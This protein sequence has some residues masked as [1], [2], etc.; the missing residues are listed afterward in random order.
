MKHIFTFKRMLAVFLAALMTCLSVSVPVSADSLTEKTFTVFSGQQVIEGWY[1]SF[2]MKHENPTLMDGFLSAVQNP[3]AAIE[4]TYTGSADISLLL[5]S[6]PQ[7]GGNS[8]PW[9]SYGDCSIKTSGNRNVAV[10]SASGLIN[11]YTSKKHDDDGQNLRLDNLMNFAIGGEGNTVYSVIVRWTTDGVPSLNINLNSA[12]QTIEGFGASYTWYGDWITSSNKKNQVFDWIFNDCEFNI[13][14]F[15][16]LNRVR[17]YGG[18]FEDTNYRARAYKAYYD[19]AVSRGIKP[20]VLVTSWGEYRDEDWVEFVDRGMHQT[21][22][23]NVPWTYYTL[24]KDSSGNYRYNDLADFCVKSVQLFFDAGIPVDYFSISNEVELQDD[25]LDEQGNPRDYSGFFFDTEETQYACSYAKAY[26]AVY[27]AFKKAFGDKAP[28]LLA[29]ETMAATPNLIKS[30][31]DPILRER[32]ETVTTIAHHLYGSAN[33]ASEFSQISNMYSSRYSIWQTEWYTNNLYD[34]A[35]EIIRELTYENLNAY[36]Y[37]D[38]VWVPDDGNCL[39]ELAGDTPWNPNA[40]AARR[41]PHYIMMHFSKYI[42]KGYIRV[43]ANSSGTGCEYVAFKSPEND[44]LVIVALNK[45]GASDTVRLNTGATVTGSEI[46]RST[47]NTTDHT[48]EQTQNSYMQKVSQTVAEGG[49]VTLPA[50]TL[51]T[52]VLDISSVVKGDADGSGNVELAD[53]VAILRSLAHLETPKF[54]PVAADLNN[55]GAVE[56]ADAVAVLR[57]LAHLG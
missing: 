36:L 34:L 37:W 26:I 33:T 40:Y 35:S 56:L 4:I 6:Y 31:V 50:N 7:G 38:G 32:P 22:Q 54:Y 47:L 53:A 10:F 28:K 13:L 52:I 11:T 48:K 29:P 1:P 45:T 19:A 44:K 17:G 5:M 2:I 30:Y 15:R 9:V 24:K 18:S 12:H 20:I 46:W 21:W 16:D 42:K 3:G 49:T 39:I 27:D 14:R 23:G 8:Y 25:R 41:G 55:S 57:R 51:T 43:D